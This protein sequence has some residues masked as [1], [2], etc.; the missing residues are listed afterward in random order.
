MLTLYRTLWWKCSLVLLVF[1]GFLGL[2]IWAIMLL[3]VTTILSS[4]SDYIMP[5][6]SCSC[7][8]AEWYF[9]C[10]F[11]F[12]FFI[13][14]LWGKVFSVS[15]INML[16]LGLWWCSLSDWG[17]SLLFLNS[18]MFCILKSWVSIKFSYFSCLCDDTTFLP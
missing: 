15:P 10:N 8:I 14:H 4:F 2:S 16:A 1:V 18:W 7:L 17:A 12:R 6:I 9:Q 13:S 11:V 5:F 3:I